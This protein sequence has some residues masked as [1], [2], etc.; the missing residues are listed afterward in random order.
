MNLTAYRR[1]VSI[2]D[3]GVRPH[4]VYFCLAVP[5]EGV[6]NGVKS[7]KIGTTYDPDRR[8][9]GL[10]RGDTTSP[11]W[12]QDTGNASR[13]DFVGFVIGDAELEKHLHRAFAEHRLAGEWFAYEPIAALVDLLLGDHCVCRGCQIGGTLANL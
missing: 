10:Q 5:K 1:A 11:D 4:Y 7:L 6:T 12:L 2:A 3:R 8:L 13:I 9:V